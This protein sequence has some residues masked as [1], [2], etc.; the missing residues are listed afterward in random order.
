MIFMFAFQVTSSNVL[1]NVYLL[2]KVSPIFQPPSSFLMARVPAPRI[3]AT[4]FKFLYGNT[5]CLSIRF[6]TFRLFCITDVK[7]H[8]LTKT[9]IS[10]LM[11]QR[12]SGWMDA[13]T[14]ALLGLAL[15]VLLEGLGLRLKPLCGAY[16]FS[17]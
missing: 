7:S 16:H 17:N 13:A 11:F 4:Y 9:S 15:W 8:E 12:G 1:P 14:V 5:P 3:R 6:C 2:N 10:F